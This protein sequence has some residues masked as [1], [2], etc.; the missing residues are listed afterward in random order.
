VYVPSL[1]YGLAVYGMNAGATVSPVVTGIVNAASYAAGSVAP[2]ELLALFGENLGPQSL[3]TGSFAPGGGTNQ[4]LYGTQ[5]TF[6]GIPAPLIYTSAGAASAIVPFEI[7]GASTVTVQVSY[8]GQVSSTQ[9]LPVAA[10]APGLFS[11][12]ATGSG[13]G[14]ILNQDYSVNSPDNPA[15]AGSVVVVYATGGGQTNP[16]SAS[17]TVTTEPMPLA[18]SVSATVG[19][20][21]AQILYAGNAGGEVAGVT[22]FNLQLPAGVTGQVPVVA[23]IGGQSS[24][25]TVTVSIQ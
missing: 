23:T 25:S 13:P 20:Q 1:D 7:A 21:P 9:T 10:A 4:Q 16:P 24:Q 22:Q 19:G 8:N 6:N 3:V 14:A 11:A 18:A 2:G 17:G 5:I 15:K 12:D